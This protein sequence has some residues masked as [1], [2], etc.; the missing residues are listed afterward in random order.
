MASLTT[1]RACAK[2]DSIQFLFS[3]GMPL[4]AQR[5]KT[6]MAP[7]QRNSSAVLPHGTVQYIFQGVDKNPAGGLFDFSQECIAD[8]RNPFRYFSFTDMHLGSHLQQTITFVRRASASRLSFSDISWPA[9]SGYIRRLGHRCRRAPAGL[10]HH[11][12]GRQGH[13]GWDSL[14]LPLSQQDLHRFGSLVIERQIHGGKWRG[15]QAFLDGV[16]EA[17]HRHIPGHLKTALLQSFQ[18]PQAPAYH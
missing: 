1:M 10:A 5:R 3:A 12:S 15:G 2:S 6:E 16:V 9:L 14:S 4:N 18:S 7:C 8:R 17:G 11:Q 13:Q